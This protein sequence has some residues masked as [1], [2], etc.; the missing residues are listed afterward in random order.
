M[1]INIKATNTTLTPA[2]KSFVED[3]LQSLSKFLKPENKLHV[4]LEVDKKHKSGDVFRVEINILPNMFYA[5][6]VG[7]DFYAALDVAL[8]KIKE[9]LMKEKDRRLTKRKDAARSAARLK[10]AI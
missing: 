3:K 2:I 6:A 10:R 1:K 5:E 8:P 7:Q 4:E 9:Q